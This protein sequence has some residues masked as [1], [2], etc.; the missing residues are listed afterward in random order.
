MLLPVCLPLSLGHASLLSQGGFYYVPKAGSLA[1]LFLNQGVKCNG[2][3]G[4]S[5]FLSIFHVS[6]HYVA[7]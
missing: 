4:H 6:F 5:G 1:K 7:G 3:C 2:W